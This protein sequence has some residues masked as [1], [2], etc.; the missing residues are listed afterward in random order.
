MSIL[1]CNRGR[2]AAWARWCCELFG[3]FHL[4]VR[5]H[6]WITSSGR[7]A[8]NTIPSSERLPFYPDGKW[9]A[10]Y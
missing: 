5:H 1:W 4:C 9:K 10:A 2:K 3:K 8:A 7:T 6:G